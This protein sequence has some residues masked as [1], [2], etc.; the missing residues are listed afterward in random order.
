MWPL[1]AN[2]WRKQL[3]ERQT[4]TDRNRKTQAG[5]QRQTDRGKHMETNRQETD[6][7][8]RTGRQRQTDIDRHIE[9]DRQR[10]AD[11]ELSMKVDLLRSMLWMSADDYH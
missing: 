7:D 10:Q 1:F 5:R 9:T 2:S 3:G 11:R 8:K 4:H 6:I